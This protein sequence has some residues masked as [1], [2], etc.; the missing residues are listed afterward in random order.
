MKSIIKKASSKKLVYVKDKLKLIKDF[1]PKEAIICGAMAG[2]AILLVLCN[3][4][5][6]VSKV[7]NENKDTNVV[8]ISHQECKIDLDGNESIYDCKETQT[9]PIHKDAKEHYNNMQDTC[10]VDR[11]E[12]FNH[13]VRCYDENKEKIK[14]LETKINNKEKMKMICLTN[15]KNQRIRCFRN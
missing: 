9:S 2:I 3:Q 5:T 14:S 8:N 10:I 13:I 11:G 7:E 4:V 15:K 12:K 1:Q 6:G